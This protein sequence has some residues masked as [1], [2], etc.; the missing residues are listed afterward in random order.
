MMLIWVHQETMIAQPIS[1][2]KRTAALGQTRF[3][4]W[5]IADFPLSASRGIIRSKP[6][7]C[8]AP[9][10][11]NLAS[12]TRRRTHQVDAGPS[13]TPM[14]GTEC[15]AQ[16]VEPEP[17]GP[18][19]SSTRPR[20]P[21]PI[22]NPKHHEGEPIPFSHP[23]EGAFAKVLDFYQMQWEHEPTTFPLE[24]D[25][26]GRVITAFSPDFYLVSEDLYIELTTMKQ[27]LVTKKNRK[28]RLLHELYPDVQCKLMYR[29]D[30]MNLAVKYGLFGDTAE[31]AT[32]GGIESEEENG[33]EPDE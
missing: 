1:E 17:T 2:V 33:S 15:T 3:S 28:L 7:S 22:P 8:E 27:S 11:W 32:E 21:Q 20:R 9:W 24:W 12:N 10:S 4:M 18:P 26:K 6:H 23:A 30:V 31:P 5:V 29:K 19:V 13:E 14:T 25:E 16:C